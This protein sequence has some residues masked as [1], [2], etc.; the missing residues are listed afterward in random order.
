MSTVYSPTR[1]AFSNA[2]HVAAQTQFYPELFGKRPLTFTDTGKTVADLE[3]AID[4]QI[5]VTLPQLR[6][7]LLFDIQERWRN[8]ADLGY[9]D[10]TVTEWNIDTNE[11]SELHKLGAHLFVYGFYDEAAD[12]IVLAVAVEVPRMLLGMVLGKLP[13]ERRPRGDQTFRTFRYRDL[14]KAGAVALMLDR[15]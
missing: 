14:H 9:G 13:S 1:Q 6:A 7:P 12:R 8:P 11:P 5:A 10:I 15:R 4:R 2:A 3:Y